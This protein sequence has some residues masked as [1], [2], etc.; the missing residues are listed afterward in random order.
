MSKVEVSKKDFLLR[1]VN[2]STPGKKLEKVIL[3]VIK[4]AMLALTKILKSP[5]KNQSRHAK[6]T[7]RNL[8][9][10]PW[11]GNR[12]AHAKPFE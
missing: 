3:N 5:R 7:G 9:T 6:K 2:N 12:A 4:N 8:P 1:R 11:S 10:D